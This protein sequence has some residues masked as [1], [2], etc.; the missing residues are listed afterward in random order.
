MALLNRLRIRFGLRTLVI[1]ITAFGVLFGTIGVRRYRDFK[2]KHAIEV[3]QETGGVVSAIDKG[4]NTRVFLQGKNFTDDQ[5]KHLAGYLRLIP[6]LRELDL[7]RTPVTDKGLAHIKRL[8]QLRLLYLFETQVSDDGIADLSQA[9]PDLVIKLEEPDPI[10]T[11]LS[12]ANIYRHAITSVAIADNGR[13]FSG[14]GDGSL[15]VWDPNDQEP[16]A[17]IDAHEDW[18]FAAT[19]NRR[20][21]VLATGGGDGIIHLWHPATARL[22]GAID[23]H[24]DDV[25]ALAFSPDGQT[26]YSTGDDMVIRKT[27]TRAGGESKI[28]GGHDD[29]IPALAIHTSGKIIASGSRDNSI[30]VWDCETGNLIRLLNQHTDDVMALSFYDN[31]A[32]LV[33]A[34]YDQTVRIWDTQ[35][36]LPLKTLRGHVGRV[37]SVAVNPNSTLIASSSENAVVL[38]EEGS[39]KVRWRNNSLKFVSRVQFSTS[40]HKLLCADASGAI[41]TLD[42]RNGRVE[43]IRATARIAL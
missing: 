14:S 10:A 36:L 25:H 22:L 1:A 11:G 13:V 20:Q 2:R 12:A 4:Q 6:E 5:L 30:R 23:V 34:S 29:T 39:G 17:T 21:D 19:L 33:S 28:L 40:G 7:V 18:V 26:I 15:R 3:I 9:L 43:R 38:W 41:S 27:S 8:R 35:T 31:G 37:Y 32:R 16:M 24:E 42:I